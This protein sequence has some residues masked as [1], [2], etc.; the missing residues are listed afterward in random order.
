MGAKSP[1][2]SVRGGV[3]LELGEVYKDL[4]WHFGGRIPAALRTQLSCIH[5]FIC[6]QPEIVGRSPETLS[7][8]EVSTVEQTLGFLLNW[9][10]GGVE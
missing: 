3:G 8:G 1:A 2:E 10:V 7:H 4:L 5:G 9:G 6:C